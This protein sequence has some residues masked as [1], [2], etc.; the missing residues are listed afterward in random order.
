MEKEIKLNLNEIENVI[1]N[2]KNGTMT[3]IKLKEVLGGKKLDNIFDTYTIDALLDNLINSGQIHSMLVQ[4]NGLNILEGLLNNQI[5]GD[6]SNFYMIKSD[7]IL[8]LTPEE[9]INMAISISAGRED[10]AKAL[11]SVWGKKIRTEACTTKKEHNKPMIQFRIGASEFEQQDFIQQIYEI[12]DIQGDGFY[13]YENKSFVINLIG[14]NLYQYLQQDFSKELSGKKS[15]FTKLIEESLEFDEEMLESYIKDGIDTAEISR[16]ILEKKECL[17]KI[18]YREEQKNIIELNSAMLQDM[19]VLGRGA[20]AVVYKY[21]DNQ[22]IKVLN[23]SGKKL[24]NERNFSQMLGVASNICIFPQNRVEIDGQFQ[25][26]TM[27]FVDGQQLQEKISEINLETLINAIKKAEQ[28]IKELAKDKVFFQDLNEGGI[29]WDEKNNK[30]KIIDTDFFEVDKD[31][32]EEECFSR[33]MTSFNTMLEMEL[34]IMAGQAKGL[35]QY[36]HAKSQ[37]RDAYRNY[38]LTS[39]MGKKSSIV[40]L[41]QVARE[42]IEKEFGIVPQNLAK[43]KELVG[44]KEIEIPDLTNIPKFLSSNKQVSTSVLGKQVVEEMSDT[45]FTDETEGKMKNQEVELQ[46]SDLEQVD[47]SEIDLNN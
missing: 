3:K 4:E 27:E 13:D 8:Q 20:C 2:I 47:T 39:L 35:S 37:F 41:I 24:Q 16:I 31:V 30:I 43:M 44:E 1:K 33:N 45:R 28:D 29:M 7:Y 10:V 23:E 22:V 32:E 46:Q 11:Q 17:S 6:L 25:G 40:D 15:I 9:K 26:Y 42:V 5:K 38:I 34:G 14:D 21:R 19:Q 36:L 18:E 12:Q